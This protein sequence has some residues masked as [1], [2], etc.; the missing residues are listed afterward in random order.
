MISGLLLAVACGVSF[1]IFLAPLRVM[2][3]WQWENVWA[4]WS[5]VG[6]AIGPLLFSIWTIPHYVEVNRFVGMP[7]LLGTAVVGAFA[8]TSGFLYAVTVP[9]IGLGLATAMNSGTS[10]AMSL[11]PLVALHPKT[12]L[13]PSGLSALLGVTL[14]ILGV[15]I[16]GAG[17]NLREAEL[18][19]NRDNG[20]T[21]D[22]IR[23]QSRM[24]FARSVVFCCLAGVITSAFNLALAFPNPVINA[25]LRFGESE[26]AASNTFTAPWLIGGAISNLIYVIFQLRKNNTFQRF[27]AP[28]WLA[29]ALWSVLMSM[30]FLFAI[31]A[32]TGAVSLMGAFGGVIAW[33]VS[34]AAMILASALWD[35]FMDKW[36]GIAARAMLCGV[37][38]LM[39][40]IVSLSFAQYFS[41]LEVS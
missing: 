14:S 11:V 32:Y 39:A 28:G 5:V 41:Q 4:V 25:A 23:V 20:A 12:L 3:A 21:I 30:V 8:G 15:T 24:S 19:K 1:G 10:M 35:V 16:C 7:L 18:N 29:C 31:Y 17:G 33:G 40:A 27:A 22:A 38:I 2:R 9:T 34:M 37:G 13:R 36:T 6:M 26:F